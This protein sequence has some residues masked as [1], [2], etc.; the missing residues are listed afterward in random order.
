MVIDSFAPMTLRPAALGA[1]LMRSEPAVAFKVD[2][3]YGAPGVSPKPS[4]LKPT[5]QL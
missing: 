5:L 3:A 4:T 1:G 2:L